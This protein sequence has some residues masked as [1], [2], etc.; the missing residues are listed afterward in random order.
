METNSNPKPNPN[1]DSRRNW[2]SQA[3]PGYAGTGREGPDDELFQLPK[4]CAVPRP[5]LSSWP[6][7]AQADGISIP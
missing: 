6:S 3:I 5:V 4:G 2:V 7:E 1:R